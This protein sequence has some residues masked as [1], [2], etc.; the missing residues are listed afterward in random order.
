MRFSL[1]IVA[2]LTS[3]FVS[4]PHAVVIRQEG[5]PETCCYSSTT[6]NPCSSPVPR[7]LEPLAPCGCWAPTAP[8]C[9]DVCCSLA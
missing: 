8:S 9:G 2:V 1:P 4:S 3:L 5:I 7:P 6:P